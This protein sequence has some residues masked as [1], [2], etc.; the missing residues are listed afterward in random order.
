[1]DFPTNFAWGAATA[2]YQI[3]GAAYEDGKGESIWDVFSHTPGRVLHGHTGDV[4]CDHYH[5]YAQDVQLMRQ[6]GLQAY[7][8]SVSWP[9]VLP[10]GT[11]AVNEK[12][13]A[14]YDRLVDTLLAAGIEPWVTLFHWD[15]PQGV[16]ERGGWLNRE[17]V[18]WFADYTAVVADRLGDRVKRWMTLNEP[19]CFISLSLETGYMA[20]A[21]KM[22]LRDCATAGHHALLAHGRCAQVLRAR[23][24]VPPVIGWAPVGFCKAPATDSPADLAAARTAM[25]AMGG[26]TLWNTVW[27]TDPVFLG[28]YPEEGLR[29]LGDDAP[30]VREGDMEAIHQVPD[31]CGV[32]TYCADYVRAGDDGQPLPVPLKP[33]HPASLMGGITGD[34][35][36][37]ISRFA[38]ERYGKPIVITENGMADTHWVS[39]DGH[40]HDPDRIDQITRY[41][42]GLAAAIREGVPVEGYFHWSLMDNFEWCKGYTNRFGLIHVDYATLKRTPKDSADFYRR[43]IESHG[44]ILPEMTPGEARSFGGKSIV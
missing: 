15:L 13:L 7:R 26:R 28:H 29:L 36:Y 32:N 42:A 34:A 25:W 40:V 31:F 33:G 12:G 20:P 16:Q 6:M 18:E 3:E 39:T 14:F 22:G 23:C 11:G 41:L 27:W 21:W 24:K 30:R 2:A 4:A 35:L 38:H 44:A 1:M 9:R 43:V 8:F 10:T 19:Q 5:R 37:W 17:I